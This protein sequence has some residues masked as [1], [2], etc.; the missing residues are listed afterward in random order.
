MSITEAQVNKLAEEAYDSFYAE[1]CDVQI[2][3]H[4]GD[5]VQGLNAMQGFDWPDFLLTGAEMEDE[6]AECEITI[7]EDAVGLLVC[8][9]AATR[10]PFVF[11]TDSEDDVMLKLNSLY[12]DSFYDECH[13]PSEQ[14]TTK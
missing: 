8:R 12:Y 11:T 4:N 1:C 14:E 13:E 2:T 5:K 10:G 6:C 7:P 3:I 9:S